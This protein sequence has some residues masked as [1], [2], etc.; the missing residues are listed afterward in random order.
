MTKAI[1]FSL[2]KNPELW[3]LWGWS[4]QVNMGN[5]GL[6]LTPVQLSETAK[7]AGQTTDFVVCLSDWTS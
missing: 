4:P 7:K 2:L 6:I 3:H 5:Q 1:N